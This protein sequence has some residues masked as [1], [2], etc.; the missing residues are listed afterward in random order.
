MEL[1]FFK[2]LALTLEP[3]STVGGGVMKT[4]SEARAAGRWTLQMSGFHRQD[5]L[6]RFIQSE[7]LEKDTLIHKT[8]FQ[9][10]TWYVVL[11]GIFDTAKEARA[12]AAQLPPGLVAQ[13]PW[14]RAIPPTDE[15]FQ[16]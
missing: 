11:H 8:R 16:P 7:G 2:K 6:A 12:V 3:L 13:K 10:K 9:G 1:F 14:V 5:S 4:W 15:L